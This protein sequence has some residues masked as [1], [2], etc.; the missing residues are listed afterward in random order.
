MILQAMGRLRGRGTSCAVAGALAIGL[1]ASASATAQQAPSDATLDTLVQEPEPTQLPQRGRVARPDDPTLGVD[2]GFG[3]WLKGQRR[4]PVKL[5]LTG[6]LE[7]FSGF[8]S[9][10]YRSDSTQSMTISVP[11]AATPGKTSVYTPVLAYPLD[12]DDITLELRDRSGRLVGVYRFSQ[13]PTDTQIRLP[14]VHADSEPLIVAI[15]PTSGPAGSVAALDAITIPGRVNGSQPLS[16]EVR[17]TD[18]A[19]LPL[20]P[21]G[22]DGASVVVVEA[23]AIRTID[24]RA[25]TALRE[26]VAQGGWLVVVATG[27]DD[28]WSGWLAPGAWSG[29]W[30]VEVASAEPGP[31][32]AS[33]A[34]VIAVDFELRRSTG[35]EAFPTSAWQPWNSYSPVTEGPTVKD[36]LPTDQG[37]NATLA[38]A[39]PSEVADPAD[40]SSGPGAPAADAATETDAAPADPT[41]LRPARTGARVLLHKDVYPI[42]VLSARWIRTTPDGRRAGWS[43]RTLRHQPVP[44]AADGPGVAPEGSSDEGLIAE[45]PMGFGWVTVLGFDPR[46]VASDGAAKASQRVWASVFNLVADP[47]AT[48]PSVAAT[49]RTLRAPASSMTSAWNGWYQVANPGV[50]VVL[51]AVAAAE[52]PGRRVFLLVAIA[53]GLVPLLIGPVD[54][55]LLRRARLAHRSWITALGWIGLASFAAWM[56][57]LAI[58]TSDSNVSRVI[59]IDVMMPVAGSGQ[60][61]PLAFATGVTGVFAGMTTRSEITGLPAR[62]TIRGLAGDT[63]W[64]NRD[65]LTSGQGELLIAQASPGPAALETSGDPW[66]G[67]GT[68][69]AAED[70]GDRLL[71]T[72]WRRW[73][74]RALEDR[75]RVRTTVRASI[76]TGPAGETRVLVTGLPPGASVR[77]GAIK[78][79]T[80][81]HDLRPAEPQAGAR[82]FSAGA[83]CEG[84]DWEPRPTPHPQYGYAYQQIVVGPTLDQTP[85]AVLLLAGPR[86][87]TDAI[88]HMLDAGA[89]DAVYLH[90]V[91]LPVS[92]GFQTPT[93]GVEQAVYRI[94]I[95]RAP[96][97]TTP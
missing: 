60:V 95:P 86:D 46:R 54:Y 5:T 28:S 71:S 82:V 66:G 31:V 62:A 91:G 76:E 42:D 25:A 16:L 85:G 13:S 44:D 53:A 19:S 67:F 9:I 33:L 45:G 84:N 41:K 32:P 50:P 34:D 72:T 26:W 73:T 55:L 52:A 63:L 35:A 97:G 68:G 78:R 80:V 8:V 7:P 56:L 17:T 75:S 11:V 51:D 6:G 29:Q 57:P 94:V 58:R 47:Q 92:V 30:P 83:R 87:R 90:V 24:P 89:W 70:F 10:R 15:G 36:S 3:S 23:D 48:G 61:E 64:Q 40:P 49:R 22:Y 69:P 81:W 93:M 59:A 43:V 18:A 79:R 4:V 14:A 1:L 88:E 21:W 2:W 37:G 96:E 38:P 20:L 65:E 39:E 77:R 74:F 12:G 27:V